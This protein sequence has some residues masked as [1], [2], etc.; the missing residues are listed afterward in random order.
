MTNRRSYFLWFWVLVFLFFFGVRFT[1]FYIDWLWFNEVGYTQTYLSILLTKIGLGVSVGLLAFAVVYG[2]LWLARKLA[3]GHE[4]TIRRGDVYTQLTVPETRQRRIALLV[5]LFVGGLM[6]LSAVPQWQIWLPY[7]HRPQIAEQD[8]L[9]SRSL[10]YYLF[11]LPWWEYV[12]AA[13]QGMAI[14]CL[15]A[16]TIVYVLKR[17]IGAMGHGWLARPAKQHIS[18]LAA[19]LFLLHGWSTYLKIPN[20]VYSPRGVVWGAS[21]TDVH[22]D[23]PLLRLLVTVLVIGALMMIANGFTVRNRLA[24]AAVGLYIIMLGAYWIYPPIIQR[25]VVTPNEV[26]KERP[27]IEFNIAAT[28]KAFGLD[29]AEERTLSGE[30]ELTVQDLK[31]NG[32]TIQNVRLWDRQPLLDSFSQL[33]V[34]RPYY[35]FISVDIDR[36]MINGEYRQTMLSPRELVSA[37]LPTRT[38]L[39]E[40]F[41]FTHGYGL[42][43]APVNRVSPTGLP[44]LFIKDLPPTSEIDLQ[45]TRPEI[46]FGEASND[47]VFVNTALK[48]FDYP[49]GED[50]VET[51]YAGQAGVPVDSFFR[52]LLLAIRYGS[53][54]IMLSND[55]TAGSRI[56]LYRNIRVRLQRIAPFLRFDRDPY[57]VIANDGR[58]YWLCDAYT[59]SDRYPYSEPITTETNDSEGIE[60]GI[61]YIR[62]SVKVLIDAYHGLTRFYLADPNDPLVQTYQRA[63]P[64]MFIPLEQMPAD[65]K[66]HVK[67]PSDLFA[68]QTRMF[69]TYHM[70]N[71]QVFYNKEDKWDIPTYSSEGE[72]HFIEPYHM[73]MRLP[74]EPREEFLLMRPFT[75]RNRDNLAAW[76]VARMDDEH[77]GKLVVY[78]LSKQKLVFGP[79]QVSAR[80]NQ[81]PEI[82]RQL[83]LWDQRGSQVL[84]GRQVVIPINESLIYVQPLYL[85]AETGKIPELKRVIVAYQNQ[86]A[87]EETLE[88]SL[89]RIFGGTTAA[90]PTTPD[91][92]SLPPP[93]AS[94]E[95]LAAQA[96]QHYDRAQDALKAGEWARYGEEIKRLGDVLNRMQKK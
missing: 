64:G 47:Y 73:I 10:S 68:I 7:I 11:E 1:G 72:E 85:R 42:T 94:L 62:N 63:F 92:P 79:K 19:V 2:N 23:L 25:I 84:L 8:P 95:S 82:S 9:F 43:L 34:F 21:Y 12:A 52:K 16:V 76:M 66:A 29:R 54:N 58:L 33:Q 41:I 50:N 86:I 75:P 31:E 15:V 91:Q 48:E 20:L 55:L 27:Y 90:Q 28:R 65:L 88:Q 93:E 53:M 13:A 89:N 30:G 56:L 14:V 22:A 83:T 46:Y 67:F 32:G 74:G 60:N 6:G 44:V 80:I 36:Y 49:A 71:P 4:I 17:F 5:S 3:P 51:T 70:T 38:W 61:N 18:I 39:N 87:M 26:D 45:V 24:V 78:R 59:V 35:R 81:D 40:R 77:Y 57:M 96:K 69:A 37:A